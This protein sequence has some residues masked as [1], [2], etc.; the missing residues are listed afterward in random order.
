MSSVGYGDIY[1]QTTSERLT[2]LP[3]IIMSSGVF[4]F[5]LN[6]IGNSVSNYNQVQNLFRE[7]MMYINRL[8]I[9][10]GMPQNL[11]LKVRRYLDFVFESMQDIKIDE[12]QVYK[13][14]N[15][16]LTEKL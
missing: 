9:K 11:R 15:K 14:L 4:S 2:A 12:K 8:N 6:K 10:Q 13:L 7:K 1:P 5:I 16:Q 3:L